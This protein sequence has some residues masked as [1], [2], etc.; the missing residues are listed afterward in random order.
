MQELEGQLQTVP[1][2]V[3]PTVT[4]KCVCLRSGSSSCSELSVEVWVGPALTAFPQSCSSHF[5]VVASVPNSCASKWSEFSCVNLGDPRPFRG[6]IQ[7]LPDLQCFSEAHHGI[8][9]AQW[10]PAQW[11]SDFTSEDW[12][13][14]VSGQV[15]DG[16][17]LWPRLRLFELPFA[18]QH[19]APGWAEQ[20]C[21]GRGGR[22]RKDVR[23]K[24]RTSFCWPFI[25]YLNISYL[26]YILLYPFV[27]FCQ[28]DIILCTAWA[29]LLN[30]KRLWHLL[31]L[32]CRRLEP[33]ELGQLRGEW[34]T[35]RFQ[36]VSREFWYCSAHCWKA[37]C[38]QYEKTKG[39]KSN[40]SRFQAK[41]SPPFAF[42]F[43]LPLAL[44]YENHQA[45]D[46]C[47]NASGLWPS[48]LGW[49]ERI[50]PRFYLAWTRWWLHVAPF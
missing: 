37:V 41:K 14:C 43:R 16:N 18:M 4:T 24:M 29:P 45:T 10:R 39:V 8:V 50:M 25:S 21:S 42:I 22:H 15:E 33:Q 36:C 17:F 40:A 26:Q 23:T 7:G 11:I 34:C 13:G 28:P 2:S 9:K 6:G 19:I 44:Q 3:L 12:Y 35:Q 48:T 1:E 27:M 49:T 46:L 30:G 31:A 47:R 5:F 38:K 20:L 32:L